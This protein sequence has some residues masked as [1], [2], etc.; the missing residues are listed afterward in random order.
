MIGAILPAPHTFI[1]V[2]IYFLFTLLLIFM[3]ISAL[4]FNFIQKNIRITCRCILIL[5]AI[6]LTSCA[7][8][9]KASSGK[10]LA[11][12]IKRGMTSEQVLKIAGRPEGRNTGLYI[13]GGEADEIW[14]YSD[15]GLN[16]IPFVGFFRGFRSNMTNV[17]FKQGRVVKTSESST[18]VW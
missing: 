2:L 13:P 17:W 10:T 9:D 15:G 3:K 1:L 16:M 18:G 7:S 14:L 6:C 4:S 8:S 12:Q 5:V 11:E